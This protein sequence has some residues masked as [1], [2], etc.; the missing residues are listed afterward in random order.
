MNISVYTS[1]WPLRLMAALLCFGLFSTTALPAQEAEEESALLEE[2]IITGSRIRKNPLNEP[3]PILNLSA[4]YID[5]TGLTNLGAV[6]QQ[7]PIMGSA[8]NTRFNVPG[9]S[10]FPQDGNG[11][12][13]GAVQISLRNLGAKR[14]LV[15]VDGRRWIAGASASGV[16]SVVDFNTI[17]DN[18]ID[19]IEILQDGASAIYGSDAIGGVINII[20]KK[21]YQGFKADAQW[22]RYISE[23]D[24]DAL[25]V[26][27]LW[28]AG[29][30]STEIVVSASYADESEIQT[31]DRAQSAYPRP[32]ATDCLGGGCSTFNPQGRVVLGPNFNFWDATLNDGVLNDG[33]D[34]IPVWDPTDPNAGDYH[35]FSNADRFN[36]NGPGF[37]FL[38]TPNQRI[39]LYANMIHS[40]TENTRFSFKA[41]Y[42]HRESQTRGAPEPFCLGAGCGTA[43]TENITIS[44]LNPY[45]PFGVDLSVANGNLEFYGRRPLES[46]GRIFDQ[47]VDTYQFTAALDGEFGNNRTYYWDLYAT[48]A[49]NRGFQQKRGAHNGANLQLAV[50][51]PDV[52]AAVSGCV[53]FNLFGG[54]GPD[55]EGSIT[56]EMLDFVGAVQRDFSEQTLV[57][58]G[59][60]ISSNIVDMPAGALAFA[61]GFEYREHDGSYQPDQLASSGNTLGIPAGATAG[62]FDVTEFYGEL[63]IP[64]L[65][66]RAGAQLLE[67]NA[68]ARS[69]DYSSV[70]QESTYKIGALWQPVE[71]ISVRGSYSTG[72]RAPGIGELFGGGAREDFQFVDPCSDVLGV[73]GS[74]NNGH[75]SPQP[76]NVIANCATLGVPVDFVQRNPQLSARSSGNEDLVAETSDNYSFGFVYSA[77]FDQNWIEGLTISFDWYDLEIDDAVQGRNPGEVLDLCAETLDAVACSNISR[78]S[79]GAISIVN[80]QLVNIGGIEASG[81]D[82]AL[83]YIAPATGIGQFN[84]RM[85]ATYLSN[86]TEITNNADGSQTSTDFTGTITDETFQ[87]AFPE[88]RMN[89]QVGWLF[90]HWDGGVGFRYVD[91][92]VQPSG[93]IL[94]SRF[95]TDLHLSYNVNTTGEGFRF[96]IGANNVFNSDP[97][98]CLN[99]CGST[100]MSAVVHDL[101]GTVGYFR[102]S[103]VH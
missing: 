54:Q 60:N 15:L 23:G 56:Q 51:D 63:N 57:N 50:G 35:G 52:C 99:T 2:V 55:G 103:W 66:D 22:G 85:M 10:G 45:N 46:G 27:G 93:D 91:D 18:V 92:L 89:T 94:K 14:T 62:E 68:A 77:N 80:N 44:A 13:A 65:A 20:T 33:M 86:Y 97:S 11:I 31:A 72:I 100:N 17:P 53:P 5:N 25:N 47:D 74:A 95:Y 3:A 73:A 98:V 29:N 48:Y 38:Q 6:L 40:F 61:A 83:N 102:V 71:S 34:N 75:D 28:G 70:G 88:W 37:N 79:T 43:L 8:I 16:P 76:A 67:L 9:N 7:L 21:D 69:S 26:S 41:S 84:L 19:R 4:D 12:G 1:K 64:L 81:M 39:N 96:T 78:S 24:G 101:P 42:T 59:G 36:F 87:R 58:I 90:D 32:F 30:D 82:F 49:Q